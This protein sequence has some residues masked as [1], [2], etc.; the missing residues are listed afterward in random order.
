VA[1]GVLL[2]SAAV[3]SALIVARASMLASE[4]SL[5]WERAV[6]D[7][8]I[9]GAST[10]EDVR[11][12]FGDVANSSLTVTKETIRAQ[13][14]A[15]IAQTLEEEEQAGVTREAVAHQEAV[16]ILDDVYGQVLVDTTQFEAESATLLAER[17]AAE[18]AASPGVVAL[19]PDLEQQLG[20]DAADASV[21]L[22]AAAIPAAV[23]F[24]LGALA[25]VSRR[26]SAL[27]AAGWLMVAVAVVWAVGVGVLV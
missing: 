26:R 25:E 14:T 19:D 3:V 20:D 18:V 23:G 4:A 6:V 13:E 15:L 17:L 2:A 5:E 7:E 8:L 10:V 1:L 12:V 27:L 21:L 9:R 11:F 22:S 16:A 24:M